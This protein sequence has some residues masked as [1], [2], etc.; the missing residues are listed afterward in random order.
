MQWHQLD[1]MQT[2]CTS[3]QTDN[4]TNRLPHHSV[5]TGRML[6]LTP[7]QQ[8]QSTVEIGLCDR[9]RDKNFIEKN[10]ARFVGPSW[11]L[12][13]NAVCL[14]LQ[15]MLEAAYHSGCHDKQH[16]HT[17]THLT[18]LFLGLPRWAGTRKVKPIW[19]LLKQ[20]TVSGSGISWAIRQVC[21][22]LQTDNHANTLPLSFLQTGCTSCRPTNSV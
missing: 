21:T 3:L 20:E 18:A 11:L 8:C 6:F 12:T 15:P 19:I 16:T 4:H 22:S 7:N 10:K 17:H 9:Q 2:I 13:G 5:F 14:F 1:H